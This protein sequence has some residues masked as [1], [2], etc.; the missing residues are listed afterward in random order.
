VWIVAIT[1]RAGGDEEAHSRAAGMDGFL[2]K[3]LTGAQLAEALA[4]VRPAET[5]DPA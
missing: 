4:A 1:A 3:P 5:V 2:R